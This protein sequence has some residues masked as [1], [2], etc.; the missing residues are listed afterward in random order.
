MLE[1][2]SCKNLIYIFESIYTTRLQ[3]TRNEGWKYGR[4]KVQVSREKEICSYRKTIRPRH[5]SSSFPFSANLR[6]AWSILWGQSRP[7]CPRRWLP[8]ASPAKAPR[9]PS[10]WFFCEQQPRKHCTFPRNGTREN[11]FARKENATSPRRLK[12][13]ALSLFNG[14][15]CSSLSRGIVDCDKR[16]GKKKKT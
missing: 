6:G 2:I 4:M 3:I 12:L 16:R 5:R 1:K 8:Q 13:V 10:P 15:Y 14:D 9:S 7:I 11:G